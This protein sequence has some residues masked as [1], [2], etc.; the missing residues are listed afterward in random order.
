MCIYCNHPIQACSVTCEN[1]AVH[2]HADSALRV[3]A[4][5]AFGHEILIAINSIGVNGTP[6]APASR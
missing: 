2:R 4:G 3:N 6:H 5:E 1:A